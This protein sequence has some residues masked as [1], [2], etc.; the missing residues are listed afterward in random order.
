MIRTQ[1][2]NI[3]TNHIKAKRSFF[4]NDFFLIPCNLNREEDL[5]LI[6]INI[7]NNIVFNIIEK[8][9]FF[10]QKGMFLKH[11]ITLGTMAKALNTNSTY[12]SKVINNIKQ[13][14]F[15]NYIN[16]LR[17]DYAIEQLKTNKKYRRYSISAIAEE[18]GFNNYKSFSRAFVKK[19]GKQISLFIKEL[20]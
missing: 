18:V 12:L 1:K 20:E 16:E 15:N 4:L 17:I 7:S 8:I 9:N 2:Y 10:E 19:T 5:F 6:K 13:K 3:D 14:S 11:S